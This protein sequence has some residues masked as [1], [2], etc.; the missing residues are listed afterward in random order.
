MTAGRPS[1]NLAPL[2]TE[3][4]LGSVAIVLVAICLLMFVLPE[5]V[6]RRGISAP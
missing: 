3:W 2:E 6:L 5:A 1:T 4:S